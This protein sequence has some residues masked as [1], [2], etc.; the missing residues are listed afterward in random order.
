MNEKMRVN[1][2]ELLPV[3]EE[4]LNEGKEICFSPN[5]ESM[6]PMLEPGR[7]SV[8]LSSPPSSLKK[9]DL[10]LYRRKN[11]AFVLHRVVKVEK[12]GSY[13]MCG[14]NQYFWERGINN[15]QII[16]IVKS[17]TR[18]G[19]EFSCTD[20]RYKCYCCFHV[21]KQHLFGLLIRIKNRLLRIVKKVKV[22]TNDKE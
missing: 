21:K 5:G 7:D 18:N 13:T 3:I 12:N 11:G 2:S 15:N 16:G 1:L 14:D 8:I 19:K 4:Q 17:F 10:P 20:F 9:Y 22:Q 6:K